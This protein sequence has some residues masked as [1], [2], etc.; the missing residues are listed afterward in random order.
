M[1]G[2]YYSRSAEEVNQD[3]DRMTKRLS[4]F[5][6]DMQQ[7]LNF[8]ELLTSTGARRWYTGA[9]ISVVIFGFNSWPALFTS[10]A[11]VELRIFYAAISL[12][13]LILFIIIP[14]LSWARSEPFKIT[15]WL[16]F[17]VLGSLW[18]L[19][20]GPSGG[21]FATFLT[22]CAAMQQHPRKT[23]LIIVSSVAVL[24]VITELLMGQ[25]LDY[26]ISMAVV[27]L[28]IGL[29]MIAFARQIEALRVL[30]ETQQ[31]LADV[32][33]KEERSRVARDMHDILGHSLTVIAVK[34]ELAGRLLD[35]APER[36]AAEIHDVEQLARGALV[37]V[38]AT[39]RGYR[40]VNVLTELVNARSALAAAGMD[41]EVPG[42]ADE[43]PAKYRELFG[44]ALREGVTNIVRH[45]HASKAVVT[46]GPNFIQIDDDGVGA[47]GSAA[48]DA[49]NGLS[50]LRERVE[51]QNVALIVGK[52]ALGGFRLRV[53]LCVLTKR[54]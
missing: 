10:D 9:G 28:S 42:A 34:A 16:V 36:A 48:A 26:A 52:S 41:A 22:V 12:L 50:G 33:V 45:S 17:A 32:A 54:G 7:A 5:A 1:P 30:R 49:G 6:Q 35:A 37:D 11:P 38:R 51:A 53:Q 27:S 15:I 20:I 31:Q 43:I 3:V 46:M 4:W 39:V 23:G 8:R 24:L 14:P 25:S 21:W 29:M 13:A 47:V 44:W 19:D 2:V 18:I 40:G